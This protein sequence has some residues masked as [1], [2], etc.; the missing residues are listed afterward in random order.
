MKRIIITESQFKRLVKNIIEEKE[1]DI[2]DDP[3]AIAL[4]EYLNIYFDEFYEENYVNPNFDLKR[5]YK[6]K[7]FGLMDIELAPDSWWASS[8]YPTPYKVSNSLLFFVATNREYYVYK[9]YTAN[10]VN[11]SK[12]IGKYNI[13]HI[14]FV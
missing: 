10:P 6:N 13:L 14:G 5:I 12:K 4:L 2:N 7:E 9:N 8:I 11:I 1:S 3:K